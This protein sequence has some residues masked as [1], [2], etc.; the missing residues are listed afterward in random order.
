MVTM[1]SLTKAQVRDSG[2]ALAL[3]ALLPALARHGWSFVIAAF[4]LLLFSMTIP[5]LFRP[6]AWLWWNLALLLNSVMSKVLLSAVFFIVVTPLSLA[7]RMAGSDPFKRKQWKKNGATAFTERNHE[8]T[9]EDLKR[10]F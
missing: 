8:Y 1:R 7:R 3:L 6:F 4:V 2:Q 5:A 9:A 10:P